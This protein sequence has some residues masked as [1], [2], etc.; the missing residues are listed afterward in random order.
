M[1]IYDYRCRKMDRVT[2]VYG[3]VYGSP[4]V[5]VTGIISC[6]LDLVYIGLIAWTRTHE[7]SLNRENIRDMKIK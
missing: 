1:Q 3:I 6:F 5:L 7:D 4:L 2:P